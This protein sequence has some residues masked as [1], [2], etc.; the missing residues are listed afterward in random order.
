MDPRDILSNFVKAINRHDVNKMYSLMTDGHTFFDARGGITHGKNKVKS[1]WENYFKLFPDYK[2]QITDIYSD[3][4][5]IEK[6][7]AFGFAHGTYENKKTESKENYWKIP[8]AW[9]IEIE[10]KNERIK[11]WQVCADQ[12]I[13]F[14]IIEKNIGEYK[15]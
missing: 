5:H 11:L 2:I 15:I 4:M 14:D 9:Q 13:V 6:V 7:A 3:F 10:W 8:A 12:K 1:I